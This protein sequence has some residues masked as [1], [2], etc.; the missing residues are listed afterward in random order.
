MAAPGEAH[1]A[2]RQAELV[3]AREAAT[4]LEDDAVEQSARHVGRSVREI[5]ADESVYL[6]SVTTTAKVLVRT[7]LAFCA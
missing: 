2:L 4:A 6:A 1:V 7:A 3:Q 5:E